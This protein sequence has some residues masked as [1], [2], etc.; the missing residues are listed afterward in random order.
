VKCHDHVWRFPY[1]ML[2][3]VVQRRCNG[4]L[5][6]LE[7]PVKNIRMGIEENTYAMSNFEIPFLHNGFCCLTCRRLWIAH[8]ENFVLWTESALTDV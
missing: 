4:S 1:K 8:V 7:N 6:I 5:I 3:R 2:A